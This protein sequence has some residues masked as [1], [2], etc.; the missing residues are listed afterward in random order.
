[1]IFEKVYDFIFELNVDSK[2]RMTQEKERNQ[3]ATPKKQAMKISKERK[4]ERD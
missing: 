3:M 2:E 4:K 1:M